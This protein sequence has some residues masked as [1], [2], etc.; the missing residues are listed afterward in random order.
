MLGP[1]GFVPAGILAVFGAGYVF[2]Y[3]KSIITS[4][5]NGEETPP[6]WPD[7]TEWQEDIVQPFGQMVALLVLDFWA[8]GHFALVAA[9][10]RKLRSRG[11][12]CRHV[13]WRVLGANGHA[14]V[15]NV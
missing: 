11:H 12:A 4:S 7:V 6:D 8:G 1:Y 5:A 15:G 13:S 3:A 10:K 9:R 2:S 14:G